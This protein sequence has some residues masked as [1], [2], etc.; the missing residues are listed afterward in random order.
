MCLPAVRY[1]FSNGTLRVDH[2]PLVW[3]GLGWALLMAWSF[4]AT[5]LLDQVQA[6]PNYSINV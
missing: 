1:H 3:S 5:T 6:L 4:A 2:R